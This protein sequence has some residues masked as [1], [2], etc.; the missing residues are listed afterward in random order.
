MIVIHDV[1]N[2]KVVEYT[3]A[4]CKNYC[5]SINSK[6]GKPRGYGRCRI[7]KD[8]VTENTVVRS[9]ESQVCYNSDK[10]EY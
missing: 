10:E 8:D 3:C 9:L 4:G 2:K 7:H 6:T 5:P 1:H